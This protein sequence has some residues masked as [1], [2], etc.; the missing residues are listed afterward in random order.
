MRLSS[1]PTLSSP[2]LT[3][4]NIFSSASTE[5]REE[6]FVCVR[7]W[8]VDAKLAREIFPNAL[9]AVVGSKC[10]G[11]SIILTKL[12]DLCDAKLC[13]FED[14][15]EAPEDIGDTT[16]LRFFVTKFP[17]HR[18]DS[19][20]LGTMRNNAKNNLFVIEASWWN[21]IRPGTRRE[22]DYIVLTGRQD[23]KTVERVW[24]QYNHLF[25]STMSHRDFAKVIDECTRNWRR[26][27]IDVSEETRQGVRPAEMF[28]IDGVV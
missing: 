4:A 25:S 8:H 14:L 20:S 26:V 5:N 13:P 16:Q 9:L 2:S 28:W 15:L 7:E 19:H 12:A 22:I 18:R 6:K 23:N 17:D 27:V 21:D 3:S 10:S 11:K 1:K 24:N